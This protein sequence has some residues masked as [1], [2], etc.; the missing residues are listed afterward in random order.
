MFYSN[1]SLLPKK[2]RGLDPKKSYK[3]GLS[4]G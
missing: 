2:S 3:V 1:I 4:E